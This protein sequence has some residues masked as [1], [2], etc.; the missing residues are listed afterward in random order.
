M[1]PYSKLGTVSQT[2]NIL[3]P[4]NHSKLALFTICQ[5]LGCHQ[6]LITNFHTASSKLSINLVVLHKVV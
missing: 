4:F 2:F 6:K 5:L 1:Q 3:V